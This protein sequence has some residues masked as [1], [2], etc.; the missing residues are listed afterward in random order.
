MTTWDNPYNRESTAREYE[1]REAERER[2]RRAY[3]DHNPPTNKDLAR[4]R[5]AADCQTCY[6]TG[7]I[8]EWEH[9]TYTS[10]YCTCAA[11]DRERALNAELDEYLRGIKEE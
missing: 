3:S 11:A 5:A 1:R 10:R 2:L 9:G 4:I 7:F 8:A 6:D